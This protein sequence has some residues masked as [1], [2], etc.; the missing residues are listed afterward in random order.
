MLAMDI[1]WQ[2]GRTADF[3]VSHTWSNNWHDTIEQLQTAVEAEHSSLASLPS[4]FSVFIDVFL[5]NQV[6]SG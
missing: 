5:V 2:A 3:F 6:C 4:D 1:M